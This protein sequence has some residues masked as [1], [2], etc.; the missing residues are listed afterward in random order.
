MSYKSYYKFSIA[1]ILLA[2]SISSYSYTCKT[3]PRSKRE[4]DGYVRSMNQSYTEG[5]SQLEELSHNIFL[6]AQ[7]KPSR[8][9]GV[10]L[11]TCSC[12]EKNKEYARA[13]LRFTT[14][15]VSI[16]SQKYHNIPALYQFKVDSIESTYNKLSSIRAHIQDV[17]KFN[18]FVADLL[19]DANLALRNTGNFT[20]AM[21]AAVVMAERSMEISQYLDSNAATII[22]QEHGFAGQRE[23]MKYQY[24]LSSFTDDRKRNKDQA[25]RTNEITGRYIRSLQ[26]LIK[27]IN[28]L[29]I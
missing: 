18:N 25:I 8:S 24:F 5:A 22:W 28:K 4:C 13:A 12:I 21:A 10:V 19:Q 15:Q 3:P 29:F 16:A 27:D 17:Q 20:D 2:F 1:V 6:A 7:D 26:S 9:G 14:L 11:I 23:F